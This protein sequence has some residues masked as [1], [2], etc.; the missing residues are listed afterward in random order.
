MNFL[1]VEFRCALRFFPAQNLPPLFPGQSILAIRLLNT[2][3]SDLPLSCNGFDQ[4][5][6]AIPAF[7]PLLLTTA[8]SSAFFDPFVQSILA[9]RHFSSKI[10]QNFNVTASIAS[11]KAVAT[12]SVKSFLTIMSVRK[13]GKY[14]NI[15]P[16]QS[17]LPQTDTHP[18]KPVDPPRNTLILSDEPFSQSR[19]TQACV[20]AFSL[21]PSSPNPS[22]L[23]TPL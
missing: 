7:A 19:L 5:S 18:S 17:L 15:A 23:Q 8:S 16:D 21:S 14:S 12:P 9:I 3:K 2:P 4:S 22:Q 10:T 11:A 6:L 13:T 1:C 20:R